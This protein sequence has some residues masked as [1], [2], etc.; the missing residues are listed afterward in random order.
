MPF[1]N[2]ALNLAA[3][4]NLSFRASR[5]YLGCI[6]VLD[7]SFTPSQSSPIVRAVV[8]PAIKSA[9]VVTALLGSFAASLAV[10]GTWQPAAL[11]CALSVH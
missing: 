7:Q 1:E 4:K 10:V 3:Y 6:L 11:L 5:P 8:R 9:V 2:S